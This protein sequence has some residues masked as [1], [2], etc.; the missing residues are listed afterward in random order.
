MS[1]DV[2]NLSVLVVDDEEKICELITVFLKSIGE[3]KSIVTANN[4]VQAMQKFQNQ[5]FD[6]VIL[7]HK[8]PGK[9]GLDFADS[10]TKSIK[11]KDLKFILISGHLHQN[12][13]IHSLNVGLKHILVKPFT[14]EQMVNKVKEVLEI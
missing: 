1:T 14:K 11:Y 8:L 4:T 7:D 5:S 2:K 13:V 6:L 9:M 12:D 3:F 10:M